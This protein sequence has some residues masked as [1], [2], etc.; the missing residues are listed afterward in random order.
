MTSREKLQI[1]GDYIE[2]NYGSKLQSQVSINHRFIISEGAKS[3]EADIFIEGNNG[4]QIA[5]E[6]ES[7]QPHPDTNVIKY[8]RW[9]KEHNIRN[10]IVLI[11]IYGSLFNNENYIARVRNTDFV[12]QQI[13]AKNFQYFS[14]KCLVDRFDKKEYFEFG[15]KVRRVLFRNLGPILKAEL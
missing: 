4:T 8:W 15:P 12:A 9:I 7:N 14:L 2:K 1:I 5:F 3:P 10:R 13:K 11:H 6:L